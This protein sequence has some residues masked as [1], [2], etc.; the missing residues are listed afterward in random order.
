[1]PMIAR[2]LAVVA[3]L[4]LVQ[5]GQADPADNAQLAVRARAILAKHCAACHGGAEPRST[6]QV[7]IHTQMVAE[8][9][10]RFVIPQQPD[11]SQALELI[12]QGSMPPGGLA[13]L[14]NDEVKDLRAWVASGAA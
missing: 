13:K 1:M 2:R 9:H 8:R 6:L 3:G 11:L 12:E 4:V 14:L 10:A 7:L 5:V